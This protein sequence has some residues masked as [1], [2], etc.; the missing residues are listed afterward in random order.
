[1]AVCE[2]LPHQFKGIFQNC[3][4]WHLFLSVTWKLV[5]NIFHFFL[6]ERWF[7]KTSFLFKFSTAPLGVVTYSA[8]IRWGHYTNFLITKAILFFLCLFFNIYVYVFI[9]VSSFVG[10]CNAHSAVWTLLVIPLMP[11]SSPMVGTERFVLWVLLLWRQ[12]SVGCLFL[13]K[14][15]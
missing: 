5:S 3:H 2:N 11:H 13:P 7:F 15:I 4:S 12:D 8:S 10:L 9:C 1:M 14:G 6:R